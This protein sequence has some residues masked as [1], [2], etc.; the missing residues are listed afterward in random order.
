MFKRVLLISVITS[1]VFSVMGF[2]QDA[3]KGETLYQ[4]KC[5]TCHGEDALGKKSE[6]APRLRGQYDWYIVSSLKKFE[7]GER[8][9]DVMMPFLKGLTESDY[10]DLAAYLSALN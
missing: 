4:A 8:K 2:A 9:N 5:I 10:E 6:K 1:L 3:A 7:S